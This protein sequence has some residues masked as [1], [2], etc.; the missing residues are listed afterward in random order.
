MEGLGLLAVDGRPVGRRAVGGRGARARSRASHRVA[1]LPP[2]P[3]DDLLPRRTAPSGSR[4]RRASCP[5]ARGRGS[6]GP[7]GPGPGRRPGR[8]PRRA[9]H[10]RGAGGR[11]PAPSARGELPAPRR[12]PRRGEAANRSRSC[13]SES[14]AAEPP[15]K[16]D[17]SCR[18]TDVAATCD[19]MPDRSRG[20]LT[21]IER[22][23]RPEPHNGTDNGNGP[24]PF[25]PTPVLSRRRPSCPECTELSSRCV[26]S[27]SYVS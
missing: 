20:S 8:R 22:P 25:I 6:S 17:P 12:R 11:C 3:A 24:S 16:S 15:A 5:A 27:R 7:S 23:A 9:G 13:R 2:S 18:A 14:P 19:M 1:L 21:S 26:G 10:R 4:R